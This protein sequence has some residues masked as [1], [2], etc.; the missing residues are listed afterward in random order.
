MYQFSRSEGYFKTEGI[1]YSHGFGI[2]TFLDIHHL[3]P[4]T[5]LHFYEFWYEISFIHL[6]GI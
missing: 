4:N 3:I 5:C 1:V 2:V 6:S